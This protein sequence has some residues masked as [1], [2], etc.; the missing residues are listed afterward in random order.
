MEETHRIPNSSLSRTL[1]LRLLPHIATTPHHMCTRA[2]PIPC[3]KIFSCRSFTNSLLV[4][5]GSVPSRPQ[6]SAQPTLSIQ[7]HQSL[8]GRFP[9]P[10]PHFFLLIV[11]PCLVFSDAAAHFAESPEPGITSHVVCCLKVHKKDKIPALVD[12]DAAP[13][14][15]S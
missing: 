2:H 11:L 15:L 6:T 9:I 8:R 3:T 5:Q 12:L 10:L 7:V 4:S 14:M 1:S 13:W